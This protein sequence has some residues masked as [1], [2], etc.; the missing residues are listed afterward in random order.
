MKININQAEKIKQF[1]DY[2]ENTYA[3]PGYVSYNYVTEHLEEKKISFQLDTL[4]YKMHQPFTL[5]QVLNVMYKEFQNDKDRQEQ[6][7][8]NYEKFENYYQKI[9]ELN[10]GLQIR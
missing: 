6:A 10:K 5:S 4:T 8:A 7:I 2:E 3:I 1:I 9:K